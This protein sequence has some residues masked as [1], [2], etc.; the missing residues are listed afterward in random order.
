[1]TTAPEHQVVSLAGL[2]HDNSETVVDYAFSGHLSPSRG[3]VP[4]S[5]RDTTI[6]NADTFRY[7]HY[8]WEAANQ[9][10][11]QR[12]RFDMLVKADG[13]VVHLFHTEFW[14]RVACGM[15]DWCYSY[16]DH[17][18][19]IT[20]ADGKPSGAVPYCDEHVREM[21]RNLN[22]LPMQLLLSERLFIGQHN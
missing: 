8:Q 12:G 7:R 14:T 15:G 22:G 3:M 1:M 20:D 9:R 18:T 19:V 17:Y 21:R 13:T 4:P 11:G 6:Q 16:A 2:V 5:Y 10:S